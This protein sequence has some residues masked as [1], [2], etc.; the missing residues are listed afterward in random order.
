MA[1]C[2]LSKEFR[3]YPGMCRLRREITLPV[4]VPLKGQV[5]DLRNGLTGTVREAWIRREFFTLEP[6]EYS[7]QTF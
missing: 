3:A 7:I 4:P 1:A 6:E 5:C 2:R